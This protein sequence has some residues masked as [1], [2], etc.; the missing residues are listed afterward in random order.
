MDVAQ[1]AAIMCLHCVHKHA[2]KQAHA[3]LTYNCSKRAC[4]W[5]CAAPKS[6][7]TRARLAW[8]KPWCV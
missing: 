8:Q 2:S 5:E 6:R 1:A 7:P 4:K 3:S